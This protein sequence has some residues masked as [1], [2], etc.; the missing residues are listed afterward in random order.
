MI[1]RAFCVMTLCLLLTLWT[2]G[3]VIPGLAKDEKLLLSPV[4]QNRIAESV[5]SGVVAYL[6][7]ELS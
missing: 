5:A 2:A 7:G 6:A 3:S 4:W 1:K